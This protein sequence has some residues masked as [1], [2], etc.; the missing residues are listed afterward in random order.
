[1]GALIPAMYPR[2]ALGKSGSRITSDGAGFGLKDVR[3]VITEE[4]VEDNSAPILRLMVVL[5]LRQRVRPGVLV[6]TS[7]AALALTRCNARQL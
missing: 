4:A 7:D 5:L 1:M 3:V 2:I 6:S